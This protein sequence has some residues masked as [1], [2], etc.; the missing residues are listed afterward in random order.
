MLDSAKIRASLRIAE[1]SVEIRHCETCE[2]KSWQ[3]KNYPPPLSPSAREGDSHEFTL[4]SANRRIYHKIAE[5]IIFLWIATRIRL[6]SFSRN[7]GV[8][9]HFERQR[10]ISKK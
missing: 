6:R 3:S 9:C 8:C 1:S 5:S 2:S 7:D 4:D 10:K